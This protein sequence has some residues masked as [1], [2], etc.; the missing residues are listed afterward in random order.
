MAKIFYDH[1]ILH[2]EITAELDVYAVSKTEREELIDLID[3][4]IHNQ[5]LSLI[6]KH[7]PHDKHEKFLLDLYHKPH[8]PALLESLKKDIDAL[9]DKIQ[10]EALKIKKDILAEIKRSQKK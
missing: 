6:L 7:L 5:V 4:A 2:E 8:D 3:Q 10:A 9:E 1:L